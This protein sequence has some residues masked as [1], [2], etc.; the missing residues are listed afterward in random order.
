MDIIK[1]VAKKAGVPVG[2][3][4]KYISNFELKP[5]TKIAIEEAIKEL[6][7]EHNIYARGF[8]INGTNTV[9]LIIPMVLL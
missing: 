5:K 4:S 1:D 8:K 2:T 7:Y 3:V 9:A 6:N